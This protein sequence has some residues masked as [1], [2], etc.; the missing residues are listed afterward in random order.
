MAQCSG[1]GGYRKITRSSNRSCP[2]KRPACPAIGDGSEVTFKPLVPSLSDKLKEYQV[3]K[4][5]ISL[6]RLT[7]R[8]R[9]KAPSSKFIVHVRLSPYL[10]IMPPGAPRHAVF[11]ETNQ[12]SCLLNPNHNA[13][14][15]DYLLLPS[16]Y[17]SSTVRVEVHILTSSAAPRCVQGDQPAVLSTESQSQ[18]PA[19]RHAVFKET[20]H[21][22]CLLNPNHNARSRDYL[23][24]PSRYFS[25]TDSVEVHILTSSAAPRCVQG[26]QP[27]VLSTES[28]SQRPVT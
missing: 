7:M 5:T 25:S 21:L 19:P 11:K 12:L 27:P 14:S 20:N 23:R 26:D 9:A 8:N 28:K 13:R 6:T 17:F 24:L 15:R 18:R 3:R 22:S 2:C 10:L 4:M 1:Y 16:R